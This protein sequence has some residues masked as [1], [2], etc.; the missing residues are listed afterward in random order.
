MIDTSLK[1]IQGAY[2]D[3]NEIKEL[4]EG[5]S[6]NYFNTKTYI[7]PNPPLDLYEDEDDQIDELLKEATNYLFDSNWVSVSALQRK[8]RIGY[9]RVLRIMDQL[10]KVGIISDPPRKLLVTKEKAQEILSKS[11]KT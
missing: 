11:E 8:F 1:R 3:D 10:K 6:K 2:I 9:N 7:L 4:C 5:I